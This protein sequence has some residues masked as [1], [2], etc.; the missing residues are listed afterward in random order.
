MKIEQKECVILLHGIM[1]SSYDMKLIEDF[2]VLNNYKVININYPSTKYNIQTLAKNIWEEEISDLKNY[3]INFVGYSM[4]G[5]IAKT[6]IEMYQPE[7]LGRV[8]FIGS[9][10]HGSEA[11]DFYK[12][13][14]IYKKFLGPS[15]QQLSAKNKLF[16][17]DITVNYELGCIAASL[18]SFGKLFYPTAY[19]II[20]GPSDGRVSVESTKVKGMKEHIIVKLPHFFMPF[21]KKVKNLVL[22]FI[23]FGSFHHKN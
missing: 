9:P 1:R 6:I 3:K 22:T 2:F 5:I 7:N 17:D 11:A 10:I 23:K 15:G 20:K 21:S 14:K 13:L 12:N 4:G 18:S 19:F 8:V 16:K